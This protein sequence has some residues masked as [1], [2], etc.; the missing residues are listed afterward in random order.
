M[1]HGTGID[2]IQ[3][4]RI[5]KSLE[6]H[7]ERFEERVFTP[8]EIEYCRSRPEPFK[9]YA[10]RFAAK[11][12]VLKSLGTGMAG[13][14]TWRDLEILN[15]ESGQPALNITG[16]CLEICESLK[17]KDIH[18]SMSHDNVYAIAQAVAEI[19]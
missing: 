6:N 11:E 2:I 17:L 4:S 15:R 1:I 7:A 9:H 13:G 10:A 18:I 5:Q 12:A 8:R 3:I 16:K 19:A 14:I